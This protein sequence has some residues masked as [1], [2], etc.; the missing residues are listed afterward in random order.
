MRRFSSTLSEGKSRRP[1]GTS[2]MPRFRTWSAERPPIGS[3]RKT[4]ASRARRHQPG[5][6]LQERA[7]AGTVGADH[8]KRFA[9]P[10]LERDVEQRLEIA[11]P[12]AQAAYR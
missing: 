8:G 5:E 2:A 11:V 3:P 7:L 10:D 9:R 6:G 12:G 4:I 1:S